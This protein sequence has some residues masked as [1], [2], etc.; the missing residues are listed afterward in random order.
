MAAWRSP[1]KVSGVEAGALNSW[2]KGALTETP[3]EDPTSR[4][5]EDKILSVST[6]TVHSEVPGELVDKEGR[7]RDRPQRALLA[8]FRQAVTTPNGWS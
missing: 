4:A 1:W 7:G 3:A 8:G 6:E 5:E 2:V